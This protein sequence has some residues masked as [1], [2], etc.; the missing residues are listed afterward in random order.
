MD[1]SQFE[2][3]VLGIDDIDRQHRKIAKSLKLFADSV[4]RRSGRHDMFLQL[5]EHV[6][7]HFA[8]EEKLLRS[9]NYPYIGGQTRSHISFLLRMDNILSAVDSGCLKLDESILQFLTD[10]L[11]TH[12][13]EKDAEFALWLKSGAGRRR[14]A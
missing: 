12:L 5:R 8:T 11:L 7:D 14:G 3:I 13:R 9:I 2:G 1:I 6:R 4:E 10:W